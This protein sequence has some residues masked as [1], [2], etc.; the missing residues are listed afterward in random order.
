MLATGKTNPR[1]E[2]I[3]GAYLFALCIYQIGIYCWPGG[4]PF[5][6]DPRAGI[7]VLLINH[8]SFDNKV[9][10]PVEWIT[11]TWLVLA[12]AMIFFRGKW[13]T[14]YLIAEMVLAAPTAYY[15]GVLAIH[16]GGHFAPA[17]IDL[18]LTVVLFFFFSLIPIALAASKI[19]SRRRAGA[20]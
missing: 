15:I 14:A 13:L 11:A 3:L 4:P 1:R 16:R 12:T 9:I 17:F 8:F 20:I 19:L 7:P 5:I 10:Y 6:L 2:R 18:V